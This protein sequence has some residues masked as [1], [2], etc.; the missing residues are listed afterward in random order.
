MGARAG[1]CLP[2][3]LGRA[4]LTGGRVI[5]HFVMDCC[6]AFTWTADTGT[7]SWLAE[8]GGASIGA[9]TRKHSRWF[10]F[11]VNE[12]IESVHASL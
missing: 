9:V 4:C 7:A 12:L 5:V 2:A 1:Q 8:R 11:F 6:V 3:S 10:T